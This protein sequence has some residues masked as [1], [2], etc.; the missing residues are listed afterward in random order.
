MAKAGRKPK[1]SHLKRVAGNPG[2]RALNAREP[3]PLPGRPECPPHLQGEAA[4]EWP[5]LVEQLEGMGILAAS[6]R[7]SMAVYCQT[8]ARWIEAERGIAD[9][10]LISHGEKGSYQNPYVSIANQAMRQLVKVAAEFGLTPSSRS[11][12][13]VPERANDELADF[14]QGKK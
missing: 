11:R 14:L 7:G 9:E 6:D 13:Q 12:V 1:P 8:W 2:K 4:A 3:K 10:G 5:R